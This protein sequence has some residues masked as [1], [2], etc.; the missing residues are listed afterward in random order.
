MG[1]VGQANKFLSRKPFRD[2]R[3]KRSANLGRCARTI[4]NARWVR[5]VHSQ[6]VEFCYADTITPNGLNIGAERL[7]AV[8]AV[9]SRDGGPSLDR[10][11]A[12]DEPAAEFDQVVERIGNLNIDEIMDERD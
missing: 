10:T 5:V 3:E 8:V 11:D 7:L 12:R 9:A 4:T 6:R 1:D 2:R